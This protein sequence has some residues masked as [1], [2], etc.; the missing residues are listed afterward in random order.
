MI[1]S[2]RRFPKESAIATTTV[3]IPAQS[4]VDRLRM[5]RRKWKPCRSLASSGAVWECGI[6][7]DGGALG[8]GRGGVTLRRLLLGGHRWGTL[9]ARRKAAVENARDLARALRDTGP[10]RRSSSA[11]ARGTVDQDSAQL[12]LADPRQAIRLEPADRAVNRNARRGRETEAD[13]RN[14]THD[15]AHQHRLILAVDQQPAVD[16]AGAA[17]LVGGVDDGHSRG[18]TARWSTVARAPGTRRSFSRRTPEPASRPSSRRARCSLR[19]R[20]AQRLSWRV[21]AESASINVRK[22]LRR[23]RRLECRGGALPFT[24]AISAAP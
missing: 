20:R 23:R 13:D 19:A 10:G 1:G 8:P 2:H 7:R 9:I 24:L 5:R 12:E 18:P 4:Q 16:D 17:R 15:V 14:L 3:G 6:P 11:I 21:S 22:R